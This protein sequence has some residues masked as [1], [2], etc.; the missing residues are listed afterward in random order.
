MKK[1]KSRRIIGRVYNL[2]LFSSKWKT[3][4]KKLDFHT[5]YSVMNKLCE[6]NSI[7]SFVHQTQNGFSIHICLL[8][9][10]DKKSEKFSC[11]IQLLRAV[12]T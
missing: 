10:N 6:I 11:G 2:Q 4:K 7:K 12:R 5:K 8:N 3:D 9:D 1:L